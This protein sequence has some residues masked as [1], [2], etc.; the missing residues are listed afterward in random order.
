MIR[1]VFVQI[2][3]DESSIFSLEDVSDQW[4][5]KQIF[6]LRANGKSSRFKISFEID[7]RA[8]A[9]ATPGPG[10]GIIPQR[11]PSHVGILQPISQLWDFSGLN[12]PSYTASTAIVFLR[13]FRKMFPVQS[14]D[15][16]ARAEA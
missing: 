6:G 8:Y 16:K 10:D 15:D 1:N 7:G 5:R 2:G 12:S 14:S 11:S 13:R 9:F 4:V 3:H